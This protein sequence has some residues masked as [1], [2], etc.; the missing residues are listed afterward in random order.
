M[1][2]TTATLKHTKVLWWNKIVALFA[3]RTNEREIKLILVALILLLVFGLAQ[4]KR[5]ELAQSRW[6]ESDFDS[7]SCVLFIG[8]TSHGSPAN[9]P[10]Q[11]Q[12]VL[13]DG[14]P[15]GTAV[16]C[17]H[18]VRRPTRQ[19]EDTSDSVRMSLVMET[20]VG[21]YQCLPNGRVA[22]HPGRLRAR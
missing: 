5:T 4:T 9:W 22:R 19:L 11:V 10:L 18:L 14:R 16:T 2:N 8:H 15:G 20:L 21:R 7:A 6:L 3:G 12:A 1:S 17:R 13:G